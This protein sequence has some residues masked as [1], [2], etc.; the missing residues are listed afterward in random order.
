MASVQV[1]RSDNLSQPHR[2]SCW[3]SQAATLLSLNLSTETQLREDTTASLIESQQDQTPLLSRLPSIKVEEHIALLGSE[4]ITQPAQP[5]LYLQ[6]VDS[7]RQRR[8][9]AQVRTGSHWLAV[10]L[11]TA[12][13]LRRAD[14]PAVLQRPAG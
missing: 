12:Y 10:E 7:R 13:P 6:E 8:A 3:A 9:L 4:C 5:A 11:N 2:R 14:M 1:S